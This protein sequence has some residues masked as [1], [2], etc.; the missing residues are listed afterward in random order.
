M[1]EKWA[2]IDQGHDIHWWD[3]DEDVSQDW[4]L[5]GRPSGESQTL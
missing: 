1:L 2:I 3:L 5:G 4:L